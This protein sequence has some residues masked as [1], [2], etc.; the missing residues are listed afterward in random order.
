MNDNL[1]RNKIYICHLLTIFS[2]FATIAIM[3]II[4]FKV[5]SLQDQIEKANNKISGYEDRV[6]L[7]EVEWV[8][9]TRPDRIRTLAS[10]YLHN[11]SYT[12]ASQIRVIDELEKYRVAN[13]QKKNNIKEIQKSQTLI[14]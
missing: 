14:N 6:E 3:F 5:E 11:N 12:M 8:Y 10:R 9:L 1:K 13:Y 4:Q 7:L 2:L